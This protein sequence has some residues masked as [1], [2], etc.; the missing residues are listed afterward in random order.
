MTKSDL[1]LSSEHRAN[2]AEFKRRREELGGGPWDETRTML[3]KCKNLGR[4]RPVSL[5]KLRCLE[6]E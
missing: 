5:P 3:H 6:D 2:L 1:N 4:K